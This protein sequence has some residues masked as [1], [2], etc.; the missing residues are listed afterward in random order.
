MRNDDRRA[1]SEEVLATFLFGFAGVPAGGRPGGDGLGSTT[2][3]L[4]SVI[5]ALGLALLGGS[6]VVHLVSTLGPE[7]L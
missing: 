3:S 4:S 2:A 6:F 5:A 1:R 7:I